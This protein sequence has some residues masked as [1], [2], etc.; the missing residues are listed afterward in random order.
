MNVWVAD[1]L[2][3][4]VQEFDENGKLLR[5]PFGEAS[6]AYGGLP[7]PKM[8]AV[9]KTGKIYV[10]DS[11]LQ[12]VQI[13]DSN[14]KLLTYFGSAGPYPG[15]MDNPVGICVHEGDLDLFSKYIHPDFEA[16]RLIL[17]S[18]QSFGLYKVGVYALG[19]LKPGKTAEDT[20]SVQAAT[21]PTG[22]TTQPQKFAGTPTT[23]PT[24][25]ETTVPATQ[26]APTTQPN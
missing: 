2:K 25:Q 8:I 3:C 22:T 16:E 23:S 10:V 1:V 15:N 12:N 6:D 21:L 17:V 4:R 20:H 19:H 14:T 9:D 7:R 24:T 18:N 13:F 5:P 26:N 11:A